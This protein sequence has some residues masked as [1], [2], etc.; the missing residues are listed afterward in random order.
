MQKTGHT[1]VGRGD[2]R[3]GHGKR[4]CK[5]KALEEEMQKLEGLKRQGLEGLRP[6]EADNIFLL[7][8][9]IS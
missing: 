9:L 6:P 4:I 2:A 5:S 3:T 8:R 1:N 7:P